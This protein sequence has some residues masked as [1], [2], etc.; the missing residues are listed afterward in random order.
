MSF[1]RKIKH[2]A[3]HQHWICSLAIVPVGIHTGVNSMACTAVQHHQ[4]AKEFWW[5]PLLI[6]TTFFG[7]HLCLS[8]SRGDRFVSE[9]YMTTLM[10]FDIQEVLTK[11]FNHSFGQSTGWLSG[12]WCGFSN[13][14][15]KEKRIHML[16]SSAIICTHINTY[17]HAHTVLCNVPVTASWDHHGICSKNA[18]LLNL[19]L[20]VV[21][22]ICSQI[23]LDSVKLP[24]IFHFVN[25]F[26]AEVAAAPQADSQFS[27]ILT[28]S[29]TRSARKNENMPD[30]SVMRLW[31]G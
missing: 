19:K 18:E 16:F 29:T 10:W 12:E 30:S 28:F 8:V 1:S 24:E 22:M 21:T 3:T 11:A 14:V 27:C 13:P 23:G 4:G 15:K 25:E 7:F 5:R 26:S 20:S 9:W 31:F 6:F 17:T 2:L